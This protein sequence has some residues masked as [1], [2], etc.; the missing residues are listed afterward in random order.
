MT[1]SLLRAN[2]NIPHTVTFIAGLHDYSPFLVLPILIE[3]WRK[4]GTEKIR[5]Y[6]H[7]LCRD[8]GTR[9]II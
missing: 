6:I 7:G 9:F 4:V 8:A 5:E 3:F 2:L 1:L